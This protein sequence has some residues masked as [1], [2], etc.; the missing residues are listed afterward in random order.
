MLEIL[1]NVVVAVAGVYIM[2]NIVDTFLYSVKDN[3]IENVRKYNR[4]R[5]VR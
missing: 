2:Y 4:K 1:I 3:K 5:G